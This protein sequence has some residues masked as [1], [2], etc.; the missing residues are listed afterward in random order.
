LKA[1]TLSPEEK[2]RLVAE[3]KFQSEE[4]RN[5]FAVIVSHT[6]SSLQKQEKMEE[7][8]AVCN[9]LKV[10]LKI[11]YKHL[12][13][14]FEEGMN[15]NALFQK[16]ASNWSFFDYELLGLII[17]A[18]CSKLKKKYRQY[19]HELE[20]YCRR[21]IVEVPAHMLDATSTSKNTVTIKYEKEFYAITLKDIKDLEVKLSRLLKTPLRLLEIEEGCTQLMFDT[22]CTITPLT[23]KERHQFPDLKIQHLCIKNANCKSSETGMYVGTRPKTLHRGEEFN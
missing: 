19:K 15:V 9:N 6:M 8:G 3:L 16:L 20:E 21:R 5:K 1:D 18:Y 7:P 11:S 4:M 10:L 13:T 17:N 22:A 23:D 14:L 12:C 2:E